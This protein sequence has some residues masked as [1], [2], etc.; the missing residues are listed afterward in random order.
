MNIICTICQSSVDE[1]SIS[2]TTCGHIFH[3][4]CILQWTDTSK[5]CPECRQELNDSNT[6][7][8]KLNLHVDEAATDSNKK[9]ITELKR[10]LGDLQ[11][12]IASLKVECSELK[13]IKAELKARG[14]ELSN[15]ASDLRDELAIKS[16]QLQQLEEG[17]NEA[18]IATQENKELEKNNIKLKARVQELSN[19]AI[20]LR[21]MEEDCANAVE[22]AIQENE[23][24]RE[25]N[26]ELETRIRELSNT[27]KH[28]RDELT[29]KSVLLRDMEENCANALQTATEANEKLR[30]CNVNLKARA[31]ELSNTA[32]HL[33][34]ELTVKSIQLREME[35]DCANAAATAIQKNEE[36]R[37][38]N[39]ELGKQVQF[40]LETEISLKNELDMKNRMLEESEENSATANIINNDLRRSRELQNERT[41]VQNWLQ[42]NYERGMGLN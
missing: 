26:V 29:N 36:L 25:R 6:S 41:T 12:T 28:L 23:S 8:I 5:T 39:T 15:T 14:R 30:E 34:E 31:R 4:H 19:T 24:L 7:I 20:E 21:G 1:S 40:L 27:A 3:Y 9:I 2:T 13:K 10:K 18:E 33:R 22:T 35:E 11:N 32:T 38:N 42:N 16:V 17:A 37:T